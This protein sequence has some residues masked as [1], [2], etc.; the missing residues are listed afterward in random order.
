MTAQVRPGANALG[1]IVA[2]G[3]YAG[4]LGYRRSRGTFGPRHAV[5]AVLDLEFADGT[6]QQVVT[7]RSWK[8]STGPML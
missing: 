2:D 4:Y 5:S 7:D 1:A 8:T 3:W 6:R